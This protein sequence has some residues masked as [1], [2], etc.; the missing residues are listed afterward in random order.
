[1]YAHPESASV[2]KGEKEESQT[3][4]SSFYGLIAASDPGLLR[5]SNRRT[6]S[7]DTQPDKTRW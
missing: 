4:L 6:S 5:L 2:R 7:K 3:Q 1:M